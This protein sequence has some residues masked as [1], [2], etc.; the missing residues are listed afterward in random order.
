MPEHL[1]LL[2]DPFQN[3]VNIYRA[4]LEEEKYS[5]ETATN[6]DEALHRLSLRQYSVFIT[7]YFYPLEDTCRMIQWLKHASPETYILMVTDAD[8]DETTYETL[9]D[10]GLD[11]LILKP[12]PPEKILVHVKKGIRQRDIILEKQQVERQTF[13]DRV[14][15]RIQQPI[16]NSV[17]FRKCL[18]QELKRARRHKHPLSLLLLRIPPGEVLGDRLENFCVELARLLRTHT[19]EEDLV[20]RENGNFGIL[21]PE[22]D[23][24]G[25][26][27]VVKRLSHLIQ[28]HPAFDSDEFLKTVVEALSFQ[29]FT[30]PERFFIPESLMPVL[31][32]VDKEYTRR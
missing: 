28:S 18:R 22:T 25:S 29:S 8:V 27:A 32:E 14:A 2:V 13:L 19:R 15:Q 4:I 17:Y 31:E 6:V 23:Q 1:I 24:G 16:F 3:L 11:D 21:L 7:E 9:F 10:I 5:V 12:Y 26:G 30:Y 20:G